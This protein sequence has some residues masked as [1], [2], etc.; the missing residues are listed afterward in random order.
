MEIKTIKNIDQ[1]TWTTFKA[2]AAK[3]NLKMSMLLK[4]MVNNFNKNS[5]QFWNNILNTEKNLS[6][7]EAND[8]TT[9]TNQTRKEK[10]FRI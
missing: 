9:T 7:K 2:T 10:G 5:K 6:D 8:L 4:L 3:N 1:E